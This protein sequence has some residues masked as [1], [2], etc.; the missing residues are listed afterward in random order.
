MSNRQKILF[1]SAIVILALIALAEGLVL[2]RNSAGGQKLSASISRTVSAWTGA[3][4]NRRSQADNA[5]TARE[6]IILHETAEDLER[7]Q[8][9]INR[10]FYEMTRDMPFS[11][12]DIR[13]ERLHDWRM[14]FD[15][16]D[17]IRRLQAEI[18]Q[19][20]QSAHESRH[21]SALNLIE[22]DWRD[23]T[24]ASSVDIA[25]DATNYIV[26]IS[27]PGFARTN[28]TINIS[29]RV[30]AIEADAQNRRQV[31]S[32]GS[33]S[34]NRFKTQIMLPE[35]TIGE[36]AQAHYQEGILRITVPRKP[37]SN[38]LARR[39]DIM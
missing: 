29:G 10:L 23:V 26:T 19:I 11:G 34:I 31:K 18:A 38:S 24:E 13:R 28:I 36:S 27:M 16:P 32:G 2:L 39:V 14:P 25:G 33:D 17:N 8:N 3:Q 15:A 35:D 4:N 12:Q 9:Q 1:I 6:D 7:M 22:Q 20:F 21:G 5:L 30:L 37:A